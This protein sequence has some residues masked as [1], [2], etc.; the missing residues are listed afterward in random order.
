M[1]LQLVEC[2]SIMFDAA[3]PP[4]QKKILYLFSRIKTLTRLGLGKRGGL[5]KKKKEQYNLMESN[6]FGSHF[7]SYV[8]HPYTQVKDHKSGYIT[9]NVNDILNGNL[10]H[11][12]LEANL[13]VEEEE[14]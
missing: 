8:L 14:E 11:E 10:L 7:R 6:S 4:R 5:E 12:L 13:G 3:P 9:N 1:S 2:G